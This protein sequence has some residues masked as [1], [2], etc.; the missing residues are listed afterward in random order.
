M[1]MTTKVPQLLPATRLGLVSL[2][3]K[4]PHATLAAL[5]KE[6]QIQIQNIDF[7][8][9]P[10]QRR[11]TDFD[12]ALVHV[13]ELGPEVIAGLDKLTR[14][15]DAPPVVLLS[16]PLS[17]QDMRQVLQIGISDW[18]PT[19]VNHAELLLAL[20]KSLRGG[21]VRNTQ[22]HAILPAVGGAGATTLALALAHQA[23]QQSGKTQR[24][25]ALFDLDFSLGNCGVYSNLSNDLDMASLAACPDRVDAE[26]IRAIQKRHEAGFHLYSFKDPALNCSNDSGE[27]VLRMLDAVSAEHSHVFL[28]MPHYATPWQRDV[29]TAV[30]S[31]TV[32]A[33]GNLAAL[34]HALDMI[35]M[36]RA[37]RGEDFPLRVVLNKRQRGFWGNNIG[38]NRLRDLLG[39][40]VFSNLP[41]DKSTLSDAIDRGLL[42]AQVN[43]RSRYVRAVRA[44]LSAL[45]TASQTGPKGV[46]R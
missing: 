26:F 11:G 30:N 3:D 8:A 43:R 14:N 36:I 16:P 23:V 35:E 28:D 27:L 41:E 5:M 18:L 20:F 37:L 32:V 4:D 46:A 21:A 29:L 34:K 38:N 1:N 10:G 39:Q 17:A 19:P 25:I 45:E 33:E 44:L 40:E 7:D 15:E 42:P 31:C 22:V 6:P 24:D 2:G 9:L 13:T 12:I